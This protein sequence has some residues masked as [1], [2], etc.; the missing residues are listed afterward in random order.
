[1]KTTGDRSVKC[2]KIHF[3]YRCLDLILAR[4]LCFAENIIIRRSLTGHTKWCSGLFLV[5]I[6]T[7]LAWLWGKYTS[8][9][10]NE[11]KW[12]L[13]TST[14][15]S[16]SLYSFLSLVALVLGNSSVAA[17]KGGGLS[18]CQQSHTK[19]AYNID[20]SFLQSTERVSSI[21]LQNYDQYVWVQGLTLIYLITE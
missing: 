19:Q 11:F 15:F 16:L 20:S 17:S 3:K 8:F 1:M 2:W 18:Q 13:N 14:D 12:H 5:G 4:M 6:G 7:L 10:S 21:V 9:L